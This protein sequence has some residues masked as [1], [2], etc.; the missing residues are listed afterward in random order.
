VPSSV[1]QATDQKAHDPYRTTIPFL[2]GLIAFCLAVI[3]GIFNAFPDPPT[4]TGSMVYQMFGTCRPDL[5]PCWQPETTIAFG[6]ETS[7][8]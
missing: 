6:P 5:L 8:D 1:Q 2:A 3:V 7:I 4:D